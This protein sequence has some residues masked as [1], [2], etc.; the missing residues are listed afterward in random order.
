MM[1]INQYS[2]PSSLS[3]LEDVQLHF[4]C[5]TAVPGLLP[6]SW[7]ERGLTAVPGL[8]LSHG[9]KGVLG[10]RK[11][12]CN[13]KWGK[14]PGGRRTLTVDT[15]MPCESEN[16]R[17]LKTGPATGRGRSLTWASMEDTSREGT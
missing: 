9:V 7:R 8:Y 14:T 17:R 13:C 6:E 12:R 1:R 10:V 5:L 3:D 15:R 11:Q 4:A 16:A 2:Q